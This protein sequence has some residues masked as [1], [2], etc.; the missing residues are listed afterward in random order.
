VDAVND[1]ISYEVRPSVK[2]RTLWDVIRL[3]HVSERR[4]Y[5]TVV[6][7]YDDQVTANR[8]ATFLK[9]YI[10]KEKGC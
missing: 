4:S 1:E 2:G 6:A 9:Y 3:V 7:T 5:G 8:V 10:P